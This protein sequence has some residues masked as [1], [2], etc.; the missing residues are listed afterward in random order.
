[1]VHEMN[2]KNGDLVVLLR[3]EGYPG[4]VGALGKIL[5]PSTNPLRWHTTFFGHPS[6]HWT[7]E[8]DTLDSHMRPIRDNPGKDETL[9]WCPVPTKETA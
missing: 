3:A 6:S 9:D 7:G 1:M 2:C 4:M 5:R 8:W